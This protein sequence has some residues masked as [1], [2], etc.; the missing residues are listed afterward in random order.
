MFSDKSIQ[1][2]LLIVIPLYFTQGW[3]FDHGSIVSQVLVGIWLLID[4]VYLFRYFLQKKFDPVGIAIIL[5]WAIN[6]ISWMVSPKTVS[7][8]DSE[9]HFIATY[10]VF[11]NISVTLLTYF[12]FRSFFDSPRFDKKYIESFSLLSFISLLILFF[13]TGQ[14]SIVISGSEE[15]TNNGAYYLASI[16]PLLG[17]FFNKRI[18]IV[19][20]TIVMVLVLLGAK[21]GAIVCVGIE[22][23]FYLYF[24]FKK[25][26]SYKNPL[27]ILGLLIIFS[28]FVYLIISTFNGNDYLQYRYNQTVS[29]DSSL[30]DEIYA[31]AIEIFSEGN[32]FELLFGHGMCACISDIG[33]Y[34]HQDWLELLVDNGIVGTL[35]Y[36]VFFICL[37]NQYRAKKKVMT[38]EERFIFLSAFFCLLLRSSFSMGYTSIESSFLIIA[39]V[40]G[41]YSEKYRVTR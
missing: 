35:L 31:S 3:L 28:V 37:Y 39:L 2:V 9:Y 11:K 29:G 8:Y 17:I 7:G 33:M 41:Q 19:F 23:V 16:V 6:A 4:L 34:A 21:R 40:Y 14:D 18:T 27:K 13:T 32:A 10:S 22:L 24:L 25:S 26:N 30:R 20:F 15:V 5:F 36:L 1:R 12:P 38:Y